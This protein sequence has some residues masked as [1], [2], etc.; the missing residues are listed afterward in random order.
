M[1]SAFAILRRQME[2]RSTAGKLNAPPHRSK[3]RWNRSGDPPLT[4]R[5]RQVPMMHKWLTQMKARGYEKGESTM[6]QFGFVWRRVVLFLVTLMVGV[7]I[8][9][10]ALI[11]SDPD[12]L[13]DVS[14][15]RYIYMAFGDNLMERDLTVGPPADTVVDKGD[16]EYYILFGKLYAGVGFVW[17]GYVETDNDN[18]DN[19]PGYEGWCNGNIDRNTFLE[20]SSPDY[21]LGFYDDDGGQFALLYSGVALDFDDNLVFW[22]SGD[23]F[24]GVFSDAGKI[25]YDGV[26]DGLLDIE[27]TYLAG[28]IRLEHTVL[29]VPE[30]ATMFLL[31]FGGLSVFLRRRKKR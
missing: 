23:A 7:G 25:E 11:I 5:N 14:Y 17:G 12:Q 1:P 31:G 8:G 13:V 27:F 18:S 20:G 4:G 9:E 21:A 15:S 6:S 24:P 22:E 26:V 30:P 29:V 3:A 28:N 2:D 10:G 19:Y 16:G